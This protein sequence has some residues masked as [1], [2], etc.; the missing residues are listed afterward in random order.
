MRYKK[1][2]NILSLQQ[3]GER[4]LARP[5]VKMAMYC[6]KFHTVCYIRINFTLT[7]LYLKIKD[8]KISKLRYCRS[9][10]LDYANYQSYFYYINMYKCPPPVWHTVTATQRTRKKF[11]F[12]QTETHKYI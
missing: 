4:S 10:K 12:S 6:G 11:F 1:L 2:F 3:T 5:I 7:N 9:G 8:M